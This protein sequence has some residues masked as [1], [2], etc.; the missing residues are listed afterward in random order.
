VRTAS[1]CWLAGAVVIAAGGPASARG[2]LPSA[3]NWNLGQDSTAACLD[4]GLRRPPPR[5]VVFGLEAPL[6]F[7]THSP[8]AEL[9]PPGAAMVHVMRYGARSSEEDRTQLWAFAR[10]AGVRDDDVVVERFLHKMVVSHSLPRPGA[11]LAGRPSVA[12]DDQP[13]L[14]VAGDWVGGHGLLA[15]AS[16][17]SGSA[18]GQ[19]AAAAAGAAAG[20]SAS[21]APQRLVG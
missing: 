19:A 13:G 21:V 16:L 9:A 7:S 20:D 10:V 17:S 12:I 8:A 5:R 15:D 1:G 2:L 4:L 6:Y 18:A 14:F 3:P 11:G